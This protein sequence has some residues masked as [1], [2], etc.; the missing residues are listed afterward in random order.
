MATPVTRGS[1]FTSRLLAILVVTY[2]TSKYLG[3]FGEVVKLFLLSKQDTVIT[4]PLNF[5]VRLDWREI[6]KLNIGKETGR[7]SKPAGHIN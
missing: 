2:F 7:N 4:K 3:V 5:S 1:V 6:I